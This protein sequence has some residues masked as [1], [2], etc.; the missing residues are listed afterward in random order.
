MRTD[1][2]FYRIFNTAPEI[3]FQLIDRP[4][5]PGYQFQS[6]EVKQTAFR[7]DGVFVPRQ[8]VEAMAGPSR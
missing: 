7:I 2:L 6:V 4:I 5:V 1:S 3:F 8:E